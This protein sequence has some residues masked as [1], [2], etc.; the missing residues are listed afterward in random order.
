MVNELVKKD[1]IWRKIAFAICKDEMLA[2]DLV[3]EMYLKLFN[4]KKEI[5]D[6]YVVLTIKTLFLDYLRKSKLKISIDNFEFKNIENNF[7]FDDK[8]K[9]FIKQLKW[10]EKELLEMSYD[11][12]LRQIEKETK[13]HYKFTERVLIKVRKKWQDQKVKD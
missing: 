9:E 13:I 6:F 8:E 5:N 10:Y 1:I 7:E 4:C 11:L 2:D 12:S 3:Q